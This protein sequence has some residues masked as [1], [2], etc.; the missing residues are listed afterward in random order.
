[1]HKEVIGSCTLYLGDCRDVFDEVEGSYDSIVSDPP[2]GMSF[3]SNHR[4]VKHKKIANDGTVDLLVWTTLL[5]VNHSSYIFCRWDN[6][7]DVPKPKSHLIWLKNG[8]SMGDLKHEH[9][10]MTESILFYP[11]KNHEWVNGRPSDVIQA[12]RTGNKLHPTQKPLDLM[13][14]IVEWTS[15]VVFD[16][17]MGSGATAVA[18][19]RLGRDFIGSELDPDYFE[20]VCKRVRDEVASPSLFQVRSIKQEKPQQVSFF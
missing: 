4:S 11:G 2:Y 18:C 9:A 3:Q 20:T 19:Q 8:M 14:R 6:L 1:M 10:R 16:P 17:F 12:A 13:E 5:P 15:G 7:A